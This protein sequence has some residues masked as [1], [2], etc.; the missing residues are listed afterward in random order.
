MDGTIQLTCAA[1]KSVWRRVDRVLVHDYYHPL[2]VVQSNVPSTA[3][4]QPVSTSPH[5]T[6]SSSL[7]PALPFFRSSLL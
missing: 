2:P 5:S 3:A 6:L 7:T 4:S 1:N